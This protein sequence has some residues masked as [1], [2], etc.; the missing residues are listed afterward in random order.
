MLHYGKTLAGWEGCCAFEEKNAFILFF[1]FINSL[2][3]EMC[4]YANVSR[5]YICQALL[6]KHGDHN[7]I[8]PQ[9]RKSWDSMEN[10]NKKRK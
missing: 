9:I 10:A 8:Q 7:I 4:I 6:L 5:F 3:T 2:I 1:F